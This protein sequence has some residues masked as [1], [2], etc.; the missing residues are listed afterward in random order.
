[1]NKI[2]SGLIIF[3]VLLSTSFAY[4]STSKD[5]VLLQNVYRKIDKF[6]PEIFQKLYSQVFRLKSK[7]K[8]IP[9]VSYMLSELWNYIKLKIDLNKL[10]EV[11]SVT[12][13]DTVKIDYN[14]VPTK[15]RLIGID[16]P[17]SY[18]T[19]YGYK[20]CYWDEASDY[21]K[22]LLNWKYIWIEFDETQDKVDKYGRL[23]VYIKLDSENINSK[24]IKEWY[25]FEYTYFKA[26]KY[27]EEFKNNEKYAKDLSKWLWH[28]STCN[29]E[30]KSVS[31]EQNS[32]TF[33][34]YYYP[35]NLDYLNMWF[36][37]EKPKYCKYMETCD[38]VKYYYNV[39][40]AKWFDWD[41]DLIPCESICWVEIWE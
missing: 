34:Q 13:W 3:F 6:K 23:L 8:N 20:E 15:L 31:G 39:C 2:I 25:A 35:N 21:L 4:T 12:D 36:S 33:V 14:W 26:Y 16:T 38:E 27:Q 17:E 18:I 10:Y 1:M 32:T 24:L 9:R 28:E 29:W 37:C 5:E 41:K 22:Q 30:R 11:L 19:R 40:W 7:Y